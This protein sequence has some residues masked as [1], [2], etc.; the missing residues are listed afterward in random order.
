MTRLRGMD[1]NIN[2]QCH[3]KYLFSL[4][5]TTVPQIPNKMANKV[6][7][8]I[9]YLGICIDEKQKA[10]KPSYLPSIWYASK[11]NIIANANNNII[12]VDKK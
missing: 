3:L 7:V 6:F 10:N 12:V 9:T 5:P 2:N 4:I 1:S 11:A 8:I